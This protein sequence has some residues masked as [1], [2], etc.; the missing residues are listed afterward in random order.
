MRLR[1]RV[2]KPRVSLQPR[3]PPVVV[4]GYGVCT[5]EASITEAAELAEQLIE[6]VQI[7]R[8]GSWAGR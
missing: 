7:A 5:F 8:R 1:Q 4:I 6:A 3:H 2:F